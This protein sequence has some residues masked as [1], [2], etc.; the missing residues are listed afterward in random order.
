MTGT[1]SRRAPAEMDLV[2]FSSSEIFRVLDRQ[3]QQRGLFKR[4]LASGATRSGSRRVD[5]LPVTP[6]LV[7]SQWRRPLRTPQLNL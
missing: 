5:L 4:L 7:L 3:R 6:P 1:S 2:S